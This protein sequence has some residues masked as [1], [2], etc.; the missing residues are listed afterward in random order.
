MSRVQPERI[1]M[2]RMNVNEMNVQSIDFGHELRDGSTPAMR[3]RRELIPATVA[4][5]R[6]GFA[7]AKTG[8]AARLTAKR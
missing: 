3:R 5:L 8:T 7:E 2:F 4:R 6:A 1:F